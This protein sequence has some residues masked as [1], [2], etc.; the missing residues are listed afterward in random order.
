MEE[1]RI[2][3]KDDFYIFVSQAGFLP[4]HNFQVTGRFVSAGVAVS[5]P[6]SV[7]AGT[8]MAWGPGSKAPADSAGALQA[9]V[10]GVLDYL[11]FTPN[12][13]YFGYYS[14]FASGI[15]NEYRVEYDAEVFRESHSPT[16]PSR[17]SAIHAFGDYVTCEK[18]ARMHHWDLSEVQEFRLLTHNL[19][20]Q[21]RVNMEIVSLARYAYPRMMLEEADLESVWSAYWNGD[22]DVTLRIPID[23]RNFEER[24]SGCIWEYLIEGV[25]EGVSSSTS[26]AGCTLRAPGEHGPGTAS[27]TPLALATV[28]AFLQTACKRQPCRHLVAACKL[29]GRAR[30]RR[31]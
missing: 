6:D 20:R 10:V 29:P 4:R 1:P 12:E 19:N 31:S 11:P 17:L 30:I 15:V 2:G 3:T 23:G 21:V 16:K 25:L 13:T 24:S 14:P 7:P 28:P 26:S 5:D 9:Y 27:C 8:I 18:V 22:P